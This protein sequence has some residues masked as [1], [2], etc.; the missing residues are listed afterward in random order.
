MSI[1]QQNTFY[2][3]S[4]HAPRNTAAVGVDRLDLALLEHSSRE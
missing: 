4:Y 1:S 3:D 2:E